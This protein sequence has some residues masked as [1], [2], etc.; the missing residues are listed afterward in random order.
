VSARELIDDCVRILAPRATG[1]GLAI[2]IVGLQDLPAI[3]G[4]E[5]RLRQVFINLLSNAIKYSSEGGRVR[6]VGERA[7]DL[8]ALRVEDEGIGMDPAHI[9]TA[10][11]P[12]ERIY[13]AETA[14][15]E[16]VGLGLTIVKT[17]VDMHGGQLDIASEIGRG[18]T[19][20]VRLPA[21]AP[22][23]A[24]PLEADAPRA[25]REVPTQ[26]RPGIA[27]AAI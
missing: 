26:R 18:T 9:E 25:A 20:T 21:G 5:T 2:E 10:L 24:R 6:V 22:Q 19:V 16:G 15:R 14:N 11:K 1:A 3:R 23:E 4:D 12:F 13:S 7:G 17:L 8:V 27:A